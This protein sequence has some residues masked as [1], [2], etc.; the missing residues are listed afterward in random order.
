MIAKR[1]HRLAQ[2]E[3]WI[4]ALDRDIGGAGRQ[5]Q[6][7]PIMNADAEDLANTISDLIGTTG[8]TGNS[9]ARGTNR[10]QNESNGRLGGTSA[11]SSNDLRIRADSATNALLVYGTDEEFRKVKSLVSRLDILPDQVLIEALIAEVTLNDELRFGVQWF[12]DSRTE[13]TLTFSDE[14]S[15]NISSRFPGFAYAFD[16]NFF[17]TAINTLSAVTDIEI[18]SSPQIITLDNQSATLQVG[19]QVPVITQSAVSID[20]PNAPVVNS[21]QFRD[22]G[23]LLTVT[24]RINDGQTVIL[25]VSQEVSNAV[26]TVTSGIDAPTIQQRRFDSTVSVEDGN[27]LALGGL[28]SSTKSQGNTGIPILKD[29]PMLGNAFSAKSDSRTRTELI[30][31]LTPHIIRSGD[32]ARQITADMKDRLERLRQSIFVQTR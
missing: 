26:P 5:F 25:D 3:G 10:R 6:F 22:T 2:A 17:K 21:V 18:I 23:I 19:D 15:G 8:G 32:D 20:N 30:I 7:L 27:T 16:G 1:P 31:F 12:F 13:G 24:P 28:I 29:I 14:G 11:L 9:E 4:K